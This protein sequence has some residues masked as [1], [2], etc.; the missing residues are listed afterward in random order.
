MTVLRG[1]IASSAFDDAE[2]LLASR[3]LDDP[4][5]R[6]SF[7]HRVPQA[8]P[9]AAIGSAAVGGAPSG[10]LHD[11]LRALADGTT[12]SRQLVDEAYAVLERT[13]GELRGIVATDI[14]AASREAEA[15][16]AARREGRGNAPLFGI[17]VTVKDVIDV[18]GLPT[19]AGSAAY[20]DHP[21]RD[22]T[23][24]ARWRAAGAIVLGKAS[25]HEFAMGVTS[26]LSANPNDPTRLPGGSSG[27]SAI[28]VATGVGFG[29][30]G[31]DTRAS[32]RVPAALSGVVGLKPTY[33]LVP[34]TGVVSL[35]WTMD[36]VAPMAASVADAA[37]LLDVLIGGTPSVVHAAGAPIGSLRIGVV[38]DAFVGA[39]DAVARAV[40]DALDGLAGAGAELVDVRRPALADFELANAA[41]LVVSRC[42]AAS[43]HRRLG[44][45]QQQYWEEVREQLER[46][47]AIPAIDYLD[48]QRLRTELGTQLL[49]AFDQVDC[50]AMP[51]ALVQAPPLDDFAEHLMSL[52][53]N[54]IPFS[55][56]G[57]PAISVPCHRP[58]ELPIGLQLVA[59][60]HREDLAVAIASAHEAV[61]ARR[62]G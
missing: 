30:L 24:V 46:A 22:A 50:L 45:D 58:D 35:S 2:Q 8:A 17:P 57:F 60:P 62:S 4:R 19:R 29:S 1:S 9:G 11:A 40:T 55:F 61:H 26:P 56:V 5:T 12:T 44:L 51:T 59:A 54:A 10:P 34:T 39:T 52:A 53:R 14:E 15:C 38:T 31:T 43:F 33:G 41:G 16:D 21:T 32:I 37:L 48:A 23:G 28:A 13:N 42:E 36:H 3:A 20:E 27:G 18:A 47:C 25:T 6:V 7:D 49:G